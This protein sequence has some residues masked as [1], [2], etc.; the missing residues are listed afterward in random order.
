MIPCYE[1][2]KC[3]D[4]TALLQAQMQYLN[5]G[6]LHENPF[7][8]MEEDVTEAAPPFNIIEEDGVHD[9]FELDLDAFVNIHIYIY[10]YICIYIPI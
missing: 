5:K 7:K 2:N 10:T 4:G 6:S 1:G 3:S 8:V 9:D